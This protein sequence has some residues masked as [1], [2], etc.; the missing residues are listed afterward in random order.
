MSS[1][2]L[3]RGRLGAKR[4]DM[5]AETRSETKGTTIFVR[6]L[7]EGT[8]V[9][10]PTEAVDLGNGLLKLVRTPNYD[11]DDEKWE[12]PPGSVF[13]GEKRCDNAGEYLLAVKP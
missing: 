2:R 4:H 10:R 3:R 13:R 5:S 6:L 7:D 8:E 1:V 12:F 9:S 11:P